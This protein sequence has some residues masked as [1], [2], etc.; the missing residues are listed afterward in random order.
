MS[1]DPRHA[2]LGEP[3]LRIAGFQLWI[4]TGPHSVSTEDPCDSWL[5]VT[6]HCGASGASVWTFGE[7]LLLTEIDDFGAACAA[8]ARGERSSAELDPIEPGL[9]VTLETVDRSEDV[10]V[11]VEITSDPS[12]QAHSFTFAIDPTELAR[13]AGECAAIVD[14]FVT[15]R[16]APDVAADG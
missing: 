8:F 1:P 15:G 3:A 7:N 12:T 13:I 14:G 11:R 10:R 9:N 5:I 16:P 6:A 4:H 2:D